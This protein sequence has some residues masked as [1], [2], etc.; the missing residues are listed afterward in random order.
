[1]ARVFPQIQPFLRA[2]KTFKNPCSMV[3]VIRN[4]KRGELVKA[5]QD[6]VIDRV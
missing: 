2:K 5:S 1:M 3:M 4:P 6:E